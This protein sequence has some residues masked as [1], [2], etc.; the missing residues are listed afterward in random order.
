MNYLLRDNL[1]FSQVTQN[2]SHNCVH[3]SDHKSQVVQNC[4]N[5]ICDLDIFLL[6]AAF[7]SSAVFSVGHYF[8]PPF[9][10]RI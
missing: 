3:N 1:K 10:A 8:S 7:L 4:D 9:L 5:L 2:T 6:S